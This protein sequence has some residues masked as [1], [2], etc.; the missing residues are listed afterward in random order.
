M[1]TAGPMPDKRIE[2]APPSC[3]SQASAVWSQVHSIPG[4]RTAEYNNDS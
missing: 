3:V 4:D 1:L 2:N